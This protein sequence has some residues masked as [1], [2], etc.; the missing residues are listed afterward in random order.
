MLLKEVPRPPGQFIFT[1]SVAPTEYPTAMFVGGIRP[2]SFWSHHRNAMRLQTQEACGMLTRSPKDETRAVT[3]A[4]QL[5]MSDSWA[6]H[7]VDLDTLYVP[8]AP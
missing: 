3:S 7:P 2:S 8:Q 1:C 6:N 4:I 5:P